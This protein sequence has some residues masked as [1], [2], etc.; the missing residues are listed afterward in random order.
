MSYAEPSRSGMNQRYG[1]Y[2]GGLGTDPVGSSGWIA[3]THDRRRAVAAILAEV[4][5]ELGSRALELV[6]IRT[7]WWQL[8]TSCG[9]GDT[10]PHEED[11][12]G[13]VEHDTCDPH[14]LPPCIEGEFAWI[15][16]QCDEGDPGAI[17]VTVVRDVVT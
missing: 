16:L 14:G 12:D 9:C 10:C 13:W 17:A 11:S 7:T 4:R 15:G 5:S 1:V 3:C 2:V 6:G 8:E